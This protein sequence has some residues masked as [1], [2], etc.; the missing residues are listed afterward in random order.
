MKLDVYGRLRL[1]VL[2]EGD[3][4]VVFRLEP[5]KRIAIPELAIPADV[6]PGEV[7]TFIDDLYHEMSGPGQGVRVIPDD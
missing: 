3:A 7:A 5:G 2:R 4:W 1:E 6:P